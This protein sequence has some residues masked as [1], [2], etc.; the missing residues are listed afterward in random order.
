V[1]LRIATRDSRLAKIQAG[2]AVERLQRALPG[3]E[4]EVVPL[5]SPGDRDRTTDLRESPADFFTR[6]LDAA[7]SGVEVDCAIHSAKDVPDPVPEGLD[8]C[9]LPWREDRRDALVA[10]AGTGVEDLSGDIRIGVSSDRRAEYCHQRFP[11]A[12]QAPVRGNIE[13]RLR[14]VDEG[15][16]DLVIMAA[17]ALNRLGLQDR[18]TDWIPLDDLPTP[19]GQGTLALTF[20]AGDARLLRL[21]SLFVNSVAFVGAGVGSAD[22]CTVAGVKALRRCDVC[23]YDALLPPALL[24]ELPSNALRIDVGK[25]SWAHHM[26]QG[27]INAALT[28]YARRG[29]RVVRLKGG[30]PGTFGRLAEEVDA[31]EQQGL[32]YRVIPGVSSLAVS[33]AATGVLLTRR[34]V[35]GGFCVVSAREKGGKVRDISNAER[36]KL[37]FVIFMGAR[38]IGEL[39]EQLLSEGVQADTPTVIVYGAGSPDESTIRASLADIS[40]LNTDCRSLNTL[41]SPGLFIVGEVARYAFNRDAGALRGDRVLLTCSDTLVDRAAHAVRDLGGRPIRLPLVRLVR[42]DGAEEAV[43]R[44]DSFDWLTLTSPSAVRILVGLFKETGRDLRNVPRIMVS[45]PATARELSLHGLNAELC[46]HREFGGEG[47]LDVARPLLEKGTRILRLGSDRAGTALADALGGAGATV[48]NVVLYC[49][50]PISHDHLPGFNSVLFCS[51]SAVDAFVGSWGAGGL[52][53]RTV[54]AIG[55]PTNK[56]LRAAGVADA[57]VPEDATVERAV[58]ALAADRILGSMMEE[59][60]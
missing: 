16:F 60:P 42:A 29:L 44:L 32:P 2:S 54:A 10:A 39:V 47:L 31:L 4:F 9:W 6:D 23:L 52:E 35:A 40:R 41:S 37:P 53:G 58:S 51:G 59:R 21:R 24:D 49:N 15:E 19:D 17:A 25:R 56:A 7:V 46:P 12:E 13:D 55:Q 48:E 27:D 43:D 38:V 20:R 36:V 33:S 28:R 57:V 3:I 26:E 1:K 14:Q 18:I 30:D 34:G 8:W 5:S 11:G 50:E 45:G 22:L